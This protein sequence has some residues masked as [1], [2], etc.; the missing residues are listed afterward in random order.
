MEADIEISNVAQVWVIQNPAVWVTDIHV[1]GIEAV[2]L[3]TES[4]TV[5]STLYYDLSKNG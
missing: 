4:D 3:K 1:T 5:G 2:V